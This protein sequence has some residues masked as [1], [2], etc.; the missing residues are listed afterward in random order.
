MLERIYHFHKKNTIVFLIKKWRIYIMAETY[1]HIP[2]KSGEF[3]PAF[4]AVIPSYI[5]YDSSLSN[6]AKMLYGEI[7]AL[8][9]AHG[10]CWASDEYFCKLYEVSYKTIRRWL[11]NLEEAG[12]IVQSKERNDVDQKLY[13]II[14]LTLPQK[15]P[16][17]KMD[18]NV[19]NSGQKCP[20]KRTKMSTVIN[21]DN[22]NNINKRAC[23]RV[24]QP[25]QKNKSDLC[26]FSQRTYNMDQLERALL[27]R[28][29]GSSE[30]NGDLCGDTG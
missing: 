22:I 14:R 3:F 18:K 28:N 16:D 4:D 20:K 19:Q 24:T 30:E 12:H 27:N 7:R 15:I 25:T 6:G 29:Y 23:A 13:R 11:A 17:R 10:F 5:R 2:E 8:T 26:N 9:N 21:K 1:I